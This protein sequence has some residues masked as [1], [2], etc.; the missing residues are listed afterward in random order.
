LA[1]IITTACPGP[2]S[3]LSAEYERATPADKSTF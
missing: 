3:A 2:D 1:R